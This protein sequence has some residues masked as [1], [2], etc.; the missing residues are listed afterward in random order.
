YLWNTGES[1][2]CINNI[3]P[4]QYFITI[5]DASKCTDTIQYT[6][7]NAAGDT[8]VITASTI[9]TCFGGNDG[10]A[11]GT[12]NQGI[13]PYTYL[14]NTSP[15]QT[16]QT[17]SG[18]TAGT[19]ILTVTDS[20]GCKSINVATIQQHTQVLPV[21][22]TPQTICIGQSATLSVSSS[23]GIPGYSYTWL[24]G[25]MKGPSINVSPTTTTTYTINTSDAYSCPG[26]PVTIAVTVNPPLSIKVSPDRSV[27]AG[28]NMSFT[29]IASGGDGTYTYN[30]I[31]STGLNIDTGTT[32]I[33][34]P[35]INTEYTVTVRDGCG[36]PPVHDSVKALINPLPIVKFSVD[37]LD[38]CTPLCV[39]FT[40][41][42][43]IASGNIKSWAWTLGDGGSST[44]QSLSY[45]YTN[46]GV[47][48]VGLVAESD[49]GCM[50]SLIVPNMISAY[51]HPIAA[52]VTSPQSTNILTPT[53]NFTDESTDVYGIKSWAWQFGDVSDSNVT[54]ENPIH[55]YTDTGT[56]CSLLTVTNIH[57]CIDTVSHCIVITPYF[58]LYIPNAFSPNADGVNDIF[59]AKGTDI[60]SF[61]MYIFDRWGMLLYYTSDINDGWN[62]TV[63]GSS[64]VVQEDTYVYLI[65]AVD[66]VQHNKHKYL[67]KVT[68]LK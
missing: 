34:T 49:S 55:T 47:F 18:L 31:P 23:G 14:W 11:T 68:L 45:C 20:T 26:V 22:S 54:I 33:S 7:A 25:G 53:I 56:F 8:A 67:G 35:T 16:T 58:T 1:T 42:S 64:N 30:W 9:V 57:G 37:K 13:P 17:A 24:P 59:T 50:D 48:S 63:N 10:T 27:C 12:G 66:C 2:T 65:N 4:A 52:F 32:V 19:Y 6:L 36:T 51:S 3:S 44:L 29:S 39:N 46:A 43:T 15:A 61:E 38:G 60:C 62:G 21:P 5:T 28:G 40:N 41:S